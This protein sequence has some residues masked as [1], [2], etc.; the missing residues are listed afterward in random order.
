[1]ITKILANGLTER[2]DIIPNLIQALLGSW[3]VV[4]END[5]DIQNIYS[6]RQVL[7]YIYSGTSLKN[8]SK[9]YKAMAI[10]VYTDGTTEFKVIDVNSTVTTS[11]EINMAI[12]FAQ[13]I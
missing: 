13:N 8:L 4:E 6:G 2:T 7:T 12:I 11:K 3:G 10:V 1:M 9:N 5:S